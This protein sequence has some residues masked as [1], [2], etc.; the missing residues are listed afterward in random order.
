MKAFITGGTGF[1]GANLVEGLAEQGIQ[2]RI[3]RRESSSLKA[4]DGLTY[5]SAIGD[6]LDPPEKLAELMAGCD[7]V[8][9]VAA[10][11][12]YWRQGEAWLYKVNVEGTK[13]MIA[14]AALA[15]PA[16]FIFTSSL[17]AM[18]LPRP[19][20]LLDEFSTFNLKPRQF[21]YGHSKHLAEIELF[22]AVDAGL[23]GIIVNPTVILGPRD[24]NQ[25]SGSFI[26]EAAKGTLKFTTPGG[27]NF[28]AVKDVVV[29]HIA[30]A[31]QGQIGQ[32]YILGG[33]NRSFRDVAELACQ[34]V[35]RPKPW[36]HLPRW[37]LPLVAGGVAAARLLLGNRIPLDANQVR[38][39]GVNIYAD[40]GKAQREMG[41]TPIPFVDTVQT[42]Y[43]WYNSHG[44]L[45]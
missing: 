13:N 12:D 10:V 8:F 33:E 25:I 3:L 4:L 2:A 27:A 19:G 45:T 1:V 28:V 41:L 9:H 17:A 7:W 5:E 38:L 37:L 20:Q 34:L 32:R 16:R 29:G 35:G 40:T 42:A 23:P 44:Y 36:L 11:A 22:R 6:I 30:A 43:D 26:I 39:S 21:P 15:R 18:G 24:V 14:A 31:R